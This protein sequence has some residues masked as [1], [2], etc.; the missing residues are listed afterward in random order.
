MPQTVKIETGDCEL[1]PIEV[2]P[3][4]AKIKFGDDLKFKNQ[5]DGNPDAEL[6]FYPVADKGVAGR[7]INNF[8]N[9]SHGT[10]LTVPASGT[11]DCEP[12]EGNFA[13][14]ISAAGHSDLDPVLIIEPQIII[15]SWILFL[16]V[17]GIAALAGA[18]GGYSLGR[19]S[20]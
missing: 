8:C 15:E 5:L 18:A 1:L 14:E 9:T 19:K 7:E 17:A 16:L 6:T 13:Y 10:T 3:H 11:V 4:V 2:G 12:A 20:G